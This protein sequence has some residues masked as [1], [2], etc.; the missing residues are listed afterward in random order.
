MVDQVQRKMDIKFKF[1]SKERNWSMSVACAYTIAYV[2]KE[3]GIHELPITENIEAM[4]KQIDRMRGEVAQSVTHYDALLADFLVENHSYILVVDGLP[5]A[6]G[7]YSAPRNR[8]ITKIVARYEPDTGKLFIAAK[9][10]RDYCVTRQFSFNSLLSLANT[11]VASK[12]LSAGA[13]VASGVTR[14]VEFDTNQVG[15]DMGMWHDM[16]S[17]D[18]TVAA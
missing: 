12:R 1:T 10:L 14:V 9:A 7:L 5:D 17:E 18:G 13:G 3:L 8:S 6:N 2:A 15:I 4:A 11:Q 16:E